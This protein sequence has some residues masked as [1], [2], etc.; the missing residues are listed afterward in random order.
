MSR[1]SLDTRNYKL[2]IRISGSVSME[3][4]R[5]RRMS[6]AV[7]FV[8]PL[9]FSCRKLQNI[10]LP[11]SCPVTVRFRSFRQRC[12]FVTFDDELRVTYVDE[13]E[14]L[15]IPIS[16]RWDLLSMIITQLQPHCPPT[17]QPPLQTPKFPISTD[18]K[19]SWASQKQAKLGCLDLSN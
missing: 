14:S 18:N 3:K 5:R 11:F 2:G 12:S 1:C 4:I 13:T 19:A 15:P 8:K 10:C 16:A 7:R 17:T 9:F 6:F